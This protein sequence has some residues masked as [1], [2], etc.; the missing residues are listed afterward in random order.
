MTVAF[1]D[2]VLL[3]EVLKPS[4]KLPLGREGLE[5]W[6]V[7][8]EGLRGWFWDRK[9]LAGTI[10]VLSMALYDLFGGADG[11]SHHSILLA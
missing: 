6:D 1:N 4:E 8:A 9:A 5:N 3:T 2:A 11:Q 7:V 10:N